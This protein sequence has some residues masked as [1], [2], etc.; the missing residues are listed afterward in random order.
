[1]FC[2][3]IISSSFVQIYEDQL[4]TITSWYSLRIWRNQFTS[5]RRHATGP[6]AVVLV[7]EVSF[8]WAAMTF[9][10]HESKRIPGPSLS[11]FCR[12]KQEIVAHGEPWF[13]TQSLAHLFRKPANLFG[14]FGEL[15]AVVPRS[16]NSNAMRFGKGEKEK[17][18]WGQDLLLVPKEFIVSWLPIH[19][20][21][22][23][24]CK[25]NIIHNPY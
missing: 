6:V 5:F 7:L 18:F 17:E 3:K 21:A 10:N 23:L 25:S 2:Y 4:R 11:F 1:M 19:Q 12:N 15:S 13:Y 9:G 16:C 22:T 14:S 20:K 24:K 8:K